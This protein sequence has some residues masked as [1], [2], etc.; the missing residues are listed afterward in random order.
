MTVCEIDKLTVVEVCVVDAREGHDEAH[1]KVDNV[2]VREE[3]L[4]GP[5]VLHTG[6]VGKLLRQSSSSSCST[7]RGPGRRRDGG[8]RD[9]GR[10]G[11][12]QHENAVNPTTQSFFLPRNEAQNL[13]S[14]TE[15]H[16]SRHPEA[17]RH[18]IFGGTC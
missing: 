2:H 16:A 15:L 10:G 7:T 5:G 13:Q 6:D 9:G 18:D 8:G 3:L 17:G 14:L 12:L 4:V 11:S 1:V